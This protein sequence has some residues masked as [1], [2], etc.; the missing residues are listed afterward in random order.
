[1]HHAFPIPAPILTQ[2]RHLF[3][4][5][6]YSHASDGYSFD[7]SQEASPVGYKTR[8][9][10]D[11]SRRLTLPEF[12]ERCYETDGQTKEEGDERRLKT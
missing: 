11:R 6:G 5:N 2:A 9:Y 1:M 12:I 8:P 4:L 3:N 7:D 10:N